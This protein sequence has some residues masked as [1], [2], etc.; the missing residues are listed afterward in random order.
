MRIYHKFGQNGNTLPF[1]GRALI[2]LSRADDP[3]EAL[4]EAEKAGETLTAKQAKEIAALQRQVA[5]EKD[6]R[7]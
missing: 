3:Q 4:A 6:R 1:S 5:E 2:E 7:V